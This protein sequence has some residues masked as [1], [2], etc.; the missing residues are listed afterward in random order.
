MQTNCKGTWGDLS[1]MVKIFSIS[2][3]DNGIY[4]SKLLISYTLVNFIESKLYLSF[5]KIMTYKLYYVQELS[6]LHSSS[7]PHPSSCRDIWWFTH[8][9]GK[10]NFSNCFDSSKCLLYQQAVT[11]WLHPSVLFLPSLVQDRAVSSDAGHPNTDEKFQS[12]LQIFKTT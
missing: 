3:C 12:V 4:A 1:G 6:S 9:F 7:L 2:W 8:F 11:T 10:N 5:S